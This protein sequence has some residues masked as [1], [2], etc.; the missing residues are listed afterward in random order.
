MNEQPNIL[1]ITADGM[2]Y[3]ALRCNGNALAQSPRLDA[4]AREGVRFTRAYCSQPICM[5]CRSSIMTGQYPSVH[6]VWQNGVPLDENLPNLPTLLGE[7]GYDTSCYGKFHFKPWLDGLDPNESGHHREYDG[8][9]PYYGFNRARVTDHSDEDRYF[10]WV[11]QH[12]PQHLELA[13]NPRREAPSDATNA[14]K[15]TL[16]AEATKSRYTADLCIDDMRHRDRDKPMFLWASFI[17]PHHPYN[18]PPPYCDMFDD[19]DFPQPPDNAGP[20]ASLPSWYHDWKRRLAEHW[21]YTDAAT[22]DWLRMRRMYQGKVAHVDDEIGRVLDAL[23]DE[24]LWHNT[25]VVYM[26]DHGTMLGDY[27]L[28]QVGEY[29]QECLVH[30][31]MIIKP[32]TGLHAST[33]ALASAI[34]VLPTMLDYAGGASPL[35]VQGHSLRGVIEGREVHVRDALMIEQ[36]WGQNPPE[37]FTT[38]VTERYKLSAATN[39]IEGELYDLHNDPREVNNLFNHGHYREIQADLMHRL[40]VELQRQRNPLPRRTGCW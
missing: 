35:G 19:A 26:S 37:G 15:G 6:G 18:P 24:G 28:V 1:F 11:N 27:G 10:D 8:D 21:G 22:R 25:L 23:R 31:P 14:W 13:R 7:L 38:L 9:G 5:P 32:P 36:R 20:D 29:S 17:D 3:D 30:V 16:P 4:L 40:A 2:R 12:H 33:D 34:D 39:G